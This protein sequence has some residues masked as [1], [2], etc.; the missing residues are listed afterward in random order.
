MD[1]QIYQFQRR[2]QATWPNGDGFV[3]VVSGA[4]RFSACYV[5]AMFS[6]HV[7]SKLV[8]FVLFKAVNRFPRFHVAQ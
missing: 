5:G 4:M 6:F 7:L 3:D 2:Q 8:D 1:A